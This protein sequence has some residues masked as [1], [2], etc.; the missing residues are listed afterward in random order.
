MEQ[1]IN[2]LSK[3]NL[4]DSIQIVIKDYEH[5]HLKQEA[6]DSLAVLYSIKALHDFKRGELNKVQEDLGQAESM[7]L[8][9]PT[10]AHES[11]LYFLCMSGDIYSN[12]GDF[13]ASTKAFNNVLEL[14]GKKP[15]NKYYVWSLGGLAT[16]KAFQG[17]L[18]EGK[19]LA[20]KTL[21]LCEKYRMD[22]ML[23]L[24]MTNLLSQIYN[25]FNQLDSNL[26]Y[27]YKTHE[28]I[29]ILFPEIHPNTVLSYSNL[30]SG[31]KNKSNY[32]KAFEFAKKAIEIAHQ[33]YKLSN[34]P[35]YIAKAIGDLGHLYHTVGEYT[36]AK[37]LMEESKVYYLK[38][39]EPHNQR[40]L[41]SYLGLSEVNIKLGEI[42]KAKYYIELAKQ[43]LAQQD[44]YQ[45]EYINSITIDEAKIAANTQ[46]YK[47]ANK[48]ALQVVDTY[49]DFENP[50]RVH[51]AALST[52]AVNLNKEKSF[53]R[54]LKYSRQQYELAKILWGDLSVE[55]Q[56]ALNNI[57]ESYVGL[58][59]TIA[60]DS[61]HHS[62]LELWND[63]SGIIDFAH[64]LP[65]SKSIVMFSL[66]ADYYIHQHPNAPMY[67]QYFQLIE[68]YDV[69]FSKMQ[70]ISAD[71]NQLEYYG[72]V[73]LDIHKP[74]LEYYAKYDQDKFL[75]TLEKIKNTLAK[76]LLKNKLNQNKEEVDMIQEF[77]E[78][79]N[80]NAD[81]SQAVRYDKYAR[82]VD[83]Y[84]GLKDSLS[85]F[86]T[87]NYIK[88]YGTNEVSLDGIKK[89]LY[90]GELLI[91]YL[92]IDSILYRM[93]Y[94]KST[95][96]IEKL[97]LSDVEQKIKA[98]I[99]DF[100]IDNAKK[101]YEILLPT[102]IEAYEKLCISPD[103]LLHYINFESLINNKGDYLLQTH[104][105]RYALS[106]SILKIQDEI[107]NQ[108]DNNSNI[109]FGLTPGF[110][111]A[112]KDALFSRNNYMDSTY[113]YYLRQP[114]LKELSQR[115]AKDAKVMCYDDLDATETNFNNNVSGY[116]IIHFG[117][118]GILDDESPMFS[119]LVLVKDS[120]EDGYLHTY[121]I[122][123]KNIDAQLAIL[124]ACSSGLGEISTGNS[125]KSLAQS[126]TRAGVPSVLMTL[127]NVDE[128]VTSE[129][130][131]YFFDNIKKGWCKSKAL[132][133]A[134]LDFL[135]QAPVELKHPYYWAGLIIIGS[136]E[137]VY[138]P[139]SWSRILLT[140]LFALLLF[141]V[142]HYFWKN[143]PV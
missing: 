136:D 128:K 69:W 99:T 13:D 74:A 22:T 77:Y 67:D 140:S 121:E 63:G 106:A 52:L 101:L 83:R 46:D 38:I 112:F 36:L 100:S 143:R 54:A 25:H 45:K 90:K 133:Q 47:T 104:T 24:T 32:P 88:K 124:A 114:F 71:K 102:N 111:D 21:D 125:I 15:D 1:H 6:W 84:Q 62:M 3:R 122:Y 60:V 117:T 43:V 91:E 79:T 73:I 42:S 107:H 33:E 87:L 66:M 139:N 138:S 76:I 120:L 142:L 41:W 40:L 50:S 29:Q 8:K 94:D 11:R 97:N 92:S 82:L 141:I 57:L 109:L 39:Y 78:L 27:T 5:E 34:N 127:N 93:C 44:V 108:L 18:I 116:N 103:N 95:I 12:M 56:L 48:L 35:T 129:I 68:G 89:V 2:G 137:A 75:L 64:L 115:L 105:V 126:F 31:Y 130:L 123:N 28:L 70:F 19:H 55:V 98:Y 53:N 59:D 119:K 9:L 134:K 81:T 131:K 10:G 51:I 17:D 135:D 110:N 86:N 80:N 113:Q 65:N 85:E 61:L 118:H 96:W 72:E 14:L 30:S 23:N 4:F 20:I 26:Y 132:R 58:G 49:T 37:Q 7:A 16:N